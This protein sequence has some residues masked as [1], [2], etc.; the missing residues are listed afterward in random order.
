[1]VRM[2][3]QG[4]I[5]YLKNLSEEEILHAVNKPFSDAACDA[6]LMDMAVIMGLLPPP[7]ARLLDLG[8]GT[9]WTSL[10]LAK[11][12]YDVTGIDISEDMILHAN[13]NKQRAEVETAHFLVGDFEELDWRAE[14]DAAVFY[15]SLHHAIDEEQALR[16]AYCALGPA[17]VCVLIEPGQ[18]HAQE[19]HSLHAVQR[20]NVTEKDMP[21]GRIIGAG[22]RAGFRSFRVYP[23]APDVKWAVYSGTAGRWL[24]RLGKKVSFFRK[25]A[26]LASLAR[27]LFFVQAKRGTVWMKK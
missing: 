19:P 2:A 26:A 3:K 20:Y 13:L 11:R 5:D 17:G 15:S 16:A 6:Y 25:L 27:I 22:Q 18:G 21:P 14:F 23:H 24:G 1:M 7:P 10:F 12:G 9:G 4:E 8:C